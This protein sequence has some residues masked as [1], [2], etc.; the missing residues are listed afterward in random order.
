MKNNKRIATVF[1]LLLSL[2]FVTVLNTVES[3]EHNYK[4]PEGYVPDEET[5]I[6]IA[7][8]VWTPIYGKQKIEEEKPYRA[9]LINGIW[10]V[11]GSL[12]RPPNGMVRAG[13]VAE[14]EINKDDGRIIR[15]SHG[16]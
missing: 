4:P 1:S 11:R 7:V 2:F 5:A 10:Y 13:G 6:R 14:A 3:Q 15:I 8:A 16:R 9:T 12:P